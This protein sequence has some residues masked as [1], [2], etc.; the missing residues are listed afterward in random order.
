MNKKEKEE[1]KKAGELS[2]KISAVVMMTLLKNTTG[3]FGLDIS[4]LAMGIEKSLTA[5]SFV[6]STKNGKDSSS[7]FDDVIKSIQG[8]HEVTLKK[9]NKIVPQEK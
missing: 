7:L 1:L 4:A 9:L 6:V 2:D 3:D 8:I 5:V